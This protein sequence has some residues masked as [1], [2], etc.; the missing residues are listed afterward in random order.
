M[1]V[2]VCKWRDSPSV[3]PLISISLINSL[4]E[5]EFRK[6]SW[7][8]TFLNS[9]SRN[10]QALLLVI[11]FHKNYSNV[12]NFSDNMY[13]ITQVISSTIFYFHFVNKHKKLLAKK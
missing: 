2:T 12:E 9:W 8:L 3:S 13:K 4:L 1:I 7:L 11:N 5:N 10:D 6:I